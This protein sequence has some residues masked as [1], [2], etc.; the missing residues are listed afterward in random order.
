[1]LA[2]TIVEIKS[3]HKRF[4]LPEVSW[5]MNLYLSNSFCIENALPNGN[6]IFLQKLKK[7]SLDNEYYLTWLIAFLLGS[8]KEAC[9]LLS[10]LISSWLEC[11]GLNKQ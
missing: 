11:D 7:V 10:S 9:L 4:L 8:S 3:W 2:M 1:M 5:K 6:T